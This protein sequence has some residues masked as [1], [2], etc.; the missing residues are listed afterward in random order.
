MRNS[1]SFD[2][3][4]SKPFTSLSIR[5]W[6][7]PGQLYRCS[8]GKLWS[9][10][11]ILTPIKFSNVPWT[12]PQP[13]EKRAAAC[14]SICRKE[15]YAAMLTGKSMALP[16]LVQKSPRLGSGLKSGVFSRPSCAAKVNTGF[17]T[18]PPSIHVAPISVTTSPN[19]QEWI[20][21]PGLE[22]EVH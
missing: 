19:Q 3:H 4:P 2:D 10:C 5:L 17:A 18:Q 21:P 11:W 8:S 13:R 15:W 7:W 22:S 12:R 16:S 1:H 6:S 9:S 14:C 20:R